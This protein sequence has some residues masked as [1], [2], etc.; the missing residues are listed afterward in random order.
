MTTVS[1]GSKDA[2]EMLHGFYKSLL[3]KYN[4]TC[5]MLNNRFTVHHYSFPIVRKEELQQIKLTLTVRLSW[6]AQ[7][8]TPE[9]YS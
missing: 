9:E 5:H 2:P 6:S 3:S 1:E 8:R 4:F 7:L